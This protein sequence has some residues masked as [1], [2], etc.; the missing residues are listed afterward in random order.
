MR[1]LLTLVN[2]ETIEYVMKKDSVSIGRSSKCDLVIAYE[3]M[4][5]KHCRIEVKNGEI[6][7]TDLGSLNGVLIDGKKIPA[8]T[9]VPFQTFLHVSFGYVTGAQLIVDEKTG[10][11]ILNPLNPKT[12]TS[13]SDNVLSKTIHTKTKQQPSKEITKKHLVLMAVAFVAILGGL[14]YVLYRD[15]EAASTVISPGQQ[16]PSPTSIDSADRF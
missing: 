3:G 5:R 11:G 15:K 7:I 14:Y 10:Q 9:S 12:D 8:N 6:F 1:L 16:Q 2:G 4:S 13:S